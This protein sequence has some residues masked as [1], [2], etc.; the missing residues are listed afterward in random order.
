MGPGHTVVSILFD[1]GDRY[2]SR[3]FSHSWFES[4]R[5]AAAA[6]RD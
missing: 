4:R 5:L 2:R 6:V 1:S 3:L